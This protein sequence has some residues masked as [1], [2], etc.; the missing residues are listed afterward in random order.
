[1]NTYDDPYVL[2]FKIAWRGNDKPQRYNE[3]G[4]HIDNNEDAYTAAKRETFEESA[5]TIN[6]NNIN[7]RKCQRVELNSYVAY[8]IH[9]TGVKFDKLYK[10]YHA[11]HNR[12]AENPKDNKHYIETNDIIILPFR[13]LSKHYKTI[14]ERTRR[15][16]F[17]LNDDNLRAIYKSKHKYTKQGNTYVFK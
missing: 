2:L 12:Y 17:Q 10:L 3:A 4:G 5:G 7:L 9:L 13:E 1:M 14:R 6:I 8:C 15:L 11:N 16:L